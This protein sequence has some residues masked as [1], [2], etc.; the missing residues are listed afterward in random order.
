MEVREDNTAPAVHPGRGGGSWQRRRLQHHM[1]P[2]K[3]PSRAISISSFSF[4][5][6]LVDTRAREA[7]EE[8]AP[9]TALQ[10]RRISAISV[11]QRVADERGE[12]LGE[13]V[14][15]QIRLESRRSAATRLL[16]CT[17]GVLLRRLASD[18]LLRGALPFAA[19]F[20]EFLP[21]H[22]SQGVPEHPDPML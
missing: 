13:T 15:Y 18:P 9:W 8:A 11:A 16:F 7:P 17:S 2:G 21:R 20:V 19:P 12:P 22:G 1:H 14:G 4:V 10:P 5:W 3:Q 6:S